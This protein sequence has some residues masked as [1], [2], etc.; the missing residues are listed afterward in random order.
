MAP[1]L[2]TRRR[3]SSIVMRIVV[4]A[5]VT[6]LM[7]LVPTAAARTTKTSRRAP[8]ACTRRH[9]GVLAD[10]A[11]AEV[12]SIAGSE[13][14]VLYGCT[15]GSSRVYRLGPI[16]HRYQRKYLEE[17]FYGLSHEVLA[18]PVIAYEEIAN[19]LGCGFC[20]WAVVVRDLRNGRVLRREP[21]GTPVQAAHEE[22]FG[23]GP[24]TTIV[25]KSDGAVAW[26]ADAHDAPPEGGFQVHASDASGSRLLA[27]GED[28]EPGSLALAESTSQQPRERP[29]SL[30][31]R[32]ELGPRASNASSAS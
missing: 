24:V 15:Y 8:R 22:N 16:A 10:D 21:T 17:G 5:L 27:I 32:Y 9:R 26:I 31:E 13:S 19:Q 14:P 18:G 11:Q 4:L 3:V 7:A 2:L 12:Y 6:A 23:V 20:Q 28:I 25:L 1:Q 29:V 30:D